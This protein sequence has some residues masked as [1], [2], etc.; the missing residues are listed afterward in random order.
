MIR[1]GLGKESTCQR[2]KEIDKRDKKQGF[3][4]ENIPFLSLFCLRFLSP[5]FVYNSFLT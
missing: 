5:L 4:E 1:D 2:N 3:L